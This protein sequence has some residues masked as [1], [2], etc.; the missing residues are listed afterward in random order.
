MEIR[1]LEG[2]GATV[3][4]LSGR[5]DGTT[6]PEVDERLLAVSAKSEVLILDLAELSYISSAGLRVL[7]KAAK[8]AQTAKQRL[9]LSGL[10]PVVKQVFDVSGFTSIF[11]LFASRDEALNSVK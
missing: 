2:G 6:S 4:Q 1:E 3:L 5:L 10:Q 8:Q 7:L 11:A 9:L